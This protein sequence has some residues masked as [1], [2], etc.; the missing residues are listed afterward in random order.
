MSNPENDRNPNLTPHQK[1]RAATAVLCDGVDQHIVASLLGTNVG[2][3]NEAA[4]AVRRALGFPMR[5]TASNPLG[6]TSMQERLPLDEAD[7][8]F[9]GS[10]P[11]LITT[12]RLT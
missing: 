12:N 11:A 8:A 7:D 9:C 3:V 2:R 10:T 6:A 5:N 4:Q 1:L